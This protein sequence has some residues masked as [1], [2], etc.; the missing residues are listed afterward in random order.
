M[1]STYERDET[2]ETKNFFVRKFV[3]AL[4]PLIKAMVVQEVMRPPLMSFRIFL[5]KFQKT[6][7]CKSEGVAN[8]LR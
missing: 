7:S 2:K 5:R 6:I 3:Q 4:V 1:R 8:A